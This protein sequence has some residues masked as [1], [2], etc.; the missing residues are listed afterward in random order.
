MEGL[1]YS[2]DKKRAWLEQ[3]HL[4]KSLEKKLGEQVDKVQ[5]YKMNSAEDQT[6]F[7]LEPGCCFILLNT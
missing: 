6:Y 2:L 7:S 4:I 5:S 3:T 1:Q